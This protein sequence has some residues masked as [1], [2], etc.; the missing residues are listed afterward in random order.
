[1]TSCG[2]GRYLDK[3]SWLLKRGAALRADFR[4][5]QPRAVMTKS[6]AKMSFMRAGSGGEVVLG[7][8]GPDEKIGE[9]ADQEEADHEVEDGIVGVGGV[10]AGILAGFGDAV[11]QLRP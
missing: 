7:G 9:E 5:P 4:T 8:D 1:M 6:Q 3:V 10:D 2:R 11:H